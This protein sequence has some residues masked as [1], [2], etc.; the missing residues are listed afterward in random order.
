MK[1]ADACVQS[2]MKLEELDTALLEMSFLQLDLT[3][4]WYQSSEVILLQLGVFGV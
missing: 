4:T 2:R 3:Q 1:T